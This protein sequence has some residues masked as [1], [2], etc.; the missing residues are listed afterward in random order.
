MSSYK[1]QPLAKPIHKMP[2]EELAHIKHLMTF[3]QS[4][5][6]Q[7]AGNLRQQ[8]IGVNHYNANTGFS[9]KSLG[10]RF[11]RYGTR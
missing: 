2:L 5:P 10:F 11:R 6:T 7:Q 3:G 9:H 1:L 8:A 4:Q